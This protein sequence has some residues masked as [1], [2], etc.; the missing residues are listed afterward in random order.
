M[1]DLE[2]LE[3]RVADLERRLGAT[4]ARWNE[5]IDPATGGVTRPRVAELERRIGE[6]VSTWNEHVEARA[7]AEKARAEEF[8]KVVDKIV[9]RFRT[10]EERLEGA[11][12]Y[13]G[14]HQRALKYA[15]GSAV[16]CDGS[17]FVALRETQNERPGSS[18]A[19]QLAVKNGAGK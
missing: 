17:L 4:I 7:V 3:N 19:W 9:A 12:S 2:N 16:T 18:D 11:M 14:V 10:I 1:E 8:L 5:F 6:M 15:K 13:R